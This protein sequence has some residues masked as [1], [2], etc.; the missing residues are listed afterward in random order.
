MK[1]S[2]F[3]VA[4]ASAVSALAV[5][6]HEH[7]DHHRRDS[8]V[9][10]T[11]FVDQNGNSVQNQGSASAVYTTVEASPSG[12]QAHNKGPQTTLAP[13]GSSSAG[14]SS[15]SSSASATSVSSSSSGSSSGSQAPSSTSSSSSPSGS[16]SSSGGS[17]GGDFQDGTIS[18]SDFGISKF[19]GVVSLDWVNKNGWASVMDMNGNTADSCQDGYYCSYACSPGM[20]KTQWPSNQPGDGKSVGGLLCKNGKL[21]RTNTD[22]NSLCESDQGG[23]S[24]VNKKDQSI[25]MCRTDYPGSEDMVIPTVVDGGSTQPLSVVKEDSYY[26]WQGKKT[27][28]QYYVN[29]A[30]VSKEDGCV[31]SNSG[32]GK[33]NWA[34]LVVGSGYTNGIT[35]LSIMPNPNNKDSP[36]FNVKIEGDNVDGDCKYE[37]GQFS[38]SGSDGCTAAVRSGSAQ[39]VFY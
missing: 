10:V 4:S 22:A 7:A 31:W 35:Y 19:D 6:A 12:L 17:D 5:P 23:S 34:P 21:Y 28:T 24:V 30:G 29:N 9:H 37:N 39:L 27:S 3:L 1:F 20:S 13:S 14:G 32:S 26:Q 18:C 38:G 36:N 25:A 8:V 15:A 16:G 11:K 2:Q 33:G